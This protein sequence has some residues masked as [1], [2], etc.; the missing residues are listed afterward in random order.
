MV[1]QCS[2]K[3]FEEN[4]FLF[5]HPVR[6]SRRGGMEKVEEYASGVSGMIEG[7]VFM[8]TSLRLTR[9]NSVIRGEVRS[10]K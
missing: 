4:I 8:G 5:R 3:E 7:P 10:K 1:I 6:R 2:T 9:R